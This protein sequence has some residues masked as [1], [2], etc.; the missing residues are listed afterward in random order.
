LRGVMP[1][2]EH[3]DALKILE[4]KTLIDVGANKGQF[5]VVARH[6]F[7]RVQIHA[8][9]PLKSERKLYQSV[10]PAPFNIHS[11]A[12]SDVSGDAR[13]FVTSKLDSS[14]L[15]IPG[16][17]QHSAYGVKGSSEVTVPV[18]RLDEVFHPWNLSRPTLLKMDVQGAELR[19]LKGSERVLRLIDAVYC[20]LS[21][22]ELYKDQ[23]LAEEIV[24]FLAHAGFTLRG[25][26]NSSCTKK[27]GP[28]QSDFL[29]LAKHRV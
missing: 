6:L 3:I 18:V 25:V 17:N 5:S 8:F 24:A 27:F 7:P 28:T 4:P 12:L 14:S 21:F 11:T 2:V 15:L 23:P 19:V 22:V 26:F 9:E 29:F 13:F 10:V 1:A 16:A 20:E